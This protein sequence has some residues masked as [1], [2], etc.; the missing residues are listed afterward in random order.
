MSSAA[1]A[2]VRVFDV[3]LPDGRTLHGY[4]SGDPDGILVVYHHGTPTSG[5]QATWWAEDAVKKGIRLVSYDRAGYGG[6]SRHEGRSVADVAADVAAVADHL[7]ADRFCTW[8]ESG[9][10]PHV[11]ACAALLPERVIAAAT[12]ASAAPYDAEGL[13]FLAG[14][15]EPN[16]EEFGAALEG[17]SALRPLLDVMRRETLAATPDQLTEVLDSLL[18]DVDKAVLTGEHAEYL[19]ASFAQSLLLGVDGWLDDDLAFTQN[20]GFSLAAIR[21]PVLICQGEEDL[22]VPF[23]H[24]AWLAGQVPGAETMLLPDEGH[25]SLGEKFGE[26]HDWLLSHR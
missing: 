21:V 26:V 8:G 2:D 13:D 3:P 5:V 23:A 24:G 1:V 16:V 11:L 4:E 22:M 7:G 9:G 15:G 17:E 20:W 18:P 10:G 25:I 19:H 12:I 14:M 6:S